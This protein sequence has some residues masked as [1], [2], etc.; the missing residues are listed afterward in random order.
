MSYW[1]VVK[2]L[3]GKERQTQEQFNK[4]IEIGELKNINGL[5]VQRKQILLLLGT[6]EENEKK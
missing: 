1:Y 5:Y 4:E 6:K 3:S 2:V